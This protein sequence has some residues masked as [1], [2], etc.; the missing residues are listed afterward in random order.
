[1]KLFI[2]GLA[3][4]LSGLIA[5][6]ASAKD[7]CGLMEINNTVFDL[8]ILEEPDCFP[9]SMLP[10][11]DA[12]AVERGLRLVDISSIVFNETGEQGMLHIFLSANQIEYWV[13]FPERDEVCLMM[14]G[15]E[16]T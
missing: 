16:A 11:P 4:L 6:T 7:Q 15:F 14:E 10:S 5:S 9:R 13:F 8:C 1:M 3:F 2:F 12:F